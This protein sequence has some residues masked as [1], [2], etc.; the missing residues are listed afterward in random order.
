LQSSGGQFSVARLA[1]EIGCSRKHLTVRFAHEFGVTPK[2]LARVLRFDRALRALKR[3][4]PSLAVLA[5]TC[6]YAD[7]AHMT[8]EFREF[9]GAPPA[10]FLRRALPDEGGFP[11]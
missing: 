8:R 4:A 11:I 9:A 7:Q 6:G 2:A 1:E 5:V 10:A 3:G